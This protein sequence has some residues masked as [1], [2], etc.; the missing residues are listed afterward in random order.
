MNGSNKVEFYTKLLWN[1]LPVTNTL[2]F[3]AHSYIMKLWISAQGWYSQY[4]I[5]FITYKLAQLAR[6]FLPAEP[7]QPSVTQHLSL[8]GPFASYKENKLSC[9]LSVMKLFDK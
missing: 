3:W 6:V 9:K 2:A 7:F 1:E 8:L 5:S 4:S